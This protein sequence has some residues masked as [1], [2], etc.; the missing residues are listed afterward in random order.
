MTS[1]TASLDVHFERLI[2]D[3]GGLLAVLQREHILLSG[4]DPAAIEEIARE[5]QRYV[6]QLHVSGQAHAAA[7]RAAGYLPT[8]PTLQDWLRQ[9]DRHSGSRLIPLWQQLESLL[10]ACRQLNQLNGGLIEINRRH[11]QRALGILLGKTEET[12]LYSSAG[13]T[14]GSGYSRTLARA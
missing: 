7:L 13:A 2:A 12:E 6:T 11:S 4:R 3:A 14:Q 8:T 9:R 10:T 5:K 1:L